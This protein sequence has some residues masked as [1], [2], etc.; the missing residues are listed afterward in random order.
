MRSP[1]ARGPAQH[2]TT[3]T[4]G[5]PCRCSGMKGSGVEGAPTRA[6][7]RARCSLRRFYPDAAHAREIDDNAT[8]AG[9]EAGH[10][11][12]ATA[13]RHRNTFLARQVD[14]S[15]HIARVG[16]AHDDHRSAVDHR[17]VDATSFLVLRIVRD[18]RLSAKTRLEISHRNRHMR[19]LP[20][21]SCC[22]RRHSDLRKGGCQPRRRQA[23]RRSVAVSQRRS[24]CANRQMASAAAQVTTNRPTMMNP[25]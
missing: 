9:A 5:S 2:A 21:L 24:M 4:N 13:N 3:A 8:V 15:D 1:S 10:A 11:V 17:V 20:Y 6:T 19:F 22:P 12:V 7:L 18:Y 14:S 16:C 25:A 23:E